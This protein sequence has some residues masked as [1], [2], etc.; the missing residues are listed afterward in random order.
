MPALTD[1]VKVGDCVTAFVMTLNREG[2]N[3]I[4]FVM[5]LIRVMRLFFIFKLKLSYN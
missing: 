2:D 4:A 1:R 3:F 5:T